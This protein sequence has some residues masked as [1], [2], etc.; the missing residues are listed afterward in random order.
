MSDRIAVMNG[1]R[2]LQIG[3]PTEIYEQ[4]N[5]RFVA[6]FIGETNFLTARCMEVKGSQA[7]YRLTSGDVIEGMAIPGLAAGSDVTVAVRPERVEL[8]QGDGPGLPAT[9]RSLLYIGNDTV[10]TALLADGT[11]LQARVQNRHGALHGIAPGAPVRVQI[12]TQALRVL[13]D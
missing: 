11:E 13:G 5:S 3:T 1:G 10:C 12:P 7:R 9:L 4:P 6:D 8:V 2:I